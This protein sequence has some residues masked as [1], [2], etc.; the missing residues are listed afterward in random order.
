LS[1]KTT[2]LCGW[3]G[4][5]WVAWLSTIAGASRVSSSKIACFCY[6]R[7][8]FLEIVTGLVLP[9]NGLRGSI[10]TEIN[11]LSRLR[12]IDLSGNPGIT[13]TIPSL[14]SIRSLSKCRSMITEGRTELKSW[15]GCVFFLSCLNFH[16]CTICR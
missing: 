8:F 5:E 6:C 7:C 15:A 13:G 16:F 4:V 2:G 9:S 11:L 12:T 3:L 10:P 14:T 1:V